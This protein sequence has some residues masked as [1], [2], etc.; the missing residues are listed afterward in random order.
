MFGSYK[1][2]V[3]TAAG[4]RR[5]MQY[6]IPQVLSSGIVDRYDLWVNT[7]DIQDIEFFKIMSAKYPIINLVWQPD[8]IVNGNKSINAFYKYCIEEDSIYFKL[9]DDIVWMEDGLIEKMVKFRVDNPDFFLVTPLVINNALTT[10]LFQVANKIKLNIYYKASSYHPILWESGKFALDLHNWFLRNYLYKDKVNELHLNGAK[11][12]ALTRFSI[13]SIMWFGSIMKEMK[14]VVVGDDEEYLSCIYP[15]MKGLCNAWNGDSVCAHFAFFTQRESLDKEN[16]LDQYGKYL[17]G[18]WE[19]DEKMRRIY[20]DV[21][22]AIRYVSLHKEEFPLAPY[23][24]IVEAKPKESSEVV[25]CLKQLIRLMLPN[26]L[27]KKVYENHLR[28]VRYILE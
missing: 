9:D 2:I 22:D 13:N 18:K 19:K 14:G 8:G 20:T 5:Y 10:Y 26:S 28:K 27:V 3:V 23:K 1:V 16:I 12:M 4:R 25:D 15:A 17:E 6:L 11:P 7:M 21:Q 24:R